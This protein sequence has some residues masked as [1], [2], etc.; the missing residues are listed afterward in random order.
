MTCEGFLLQPGGCSPVKLLGFTCFCEKDH[1][2]VKAIY[3]LPLFFCYNFTQKFCHPKF[4]YYNYY[5][6]VAHLGNILT[7]HVKWGA[8]TLHTAKPLKRGQIVL[9][10]KCVFE[11]ESHRKKDFENIMPEQISKR[12]LASL[13]CK[14]TFLEYSIGESMNCCSGYS[15]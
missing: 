15:V 14:N 3:F 13:S 5:L 8:C 4:T 1:F 10:T 9:T 12:M 6:P 11:T 2:S 7:W